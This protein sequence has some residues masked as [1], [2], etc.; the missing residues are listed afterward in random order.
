MNTKFTAIALLAV[1]LIAGSVQAQSVVIGQPTMQAKQVSMSNIDHSSWNQ[2][3]QTYVNE[4][5]QVNYRGWQAS[6]EATQALD[7][8][9]AQL[10]TANPNVQADRNS[11][12]AFWINAYNAVTI[13]GILKEYPTTS[14]RNHTSET[15]GYNIWKNLMLTVGNGQYSLNSME[16]EILRKM[17]EPRIHFAIVCA[18]HSCPR[19][20]NQAY[21]ASDLENQL[22]LNTKNFFANP[23]NLKYNQSRGSFQLSALLDWFKT[24]FGPTQSDQL[25]YLSAYM[26]PAAA[27]AAQNNAVRNISYL[28][29]SWALNELK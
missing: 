17:G 25:R 5:G 1:T 23:E 6:G 26:P 7:T 11:T 10:T 19:L 24:D 18:S 20:L 3:L 28:D 2:L 16:H 15:G 29:Y 14:I 4:K 21:T 13:K 12:L 22:T 27:T 9:L 8:Y